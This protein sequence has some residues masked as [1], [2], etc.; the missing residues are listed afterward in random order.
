MFKLLIM[1]SGMK[2]LIISD[3][4]HP[5]VNGVVRSYEGLIPALHAQGHAVKVIGPD[6][7]PHRFGMVGYKEI[8]LVFKPYKRLSQMIEDYRP[9]TIHIATE[10]PLGWVARRYCLRRGIKFTSCY[11][12][13]F[14]EYFAK[15]FEKIWRGFYK[16]VYTIGVAVVKK[17]HAPSSALLVTTAS[18]AARLKKMGVQAPLHFF[19]RG[20]DNDF[21]HL[22]N[23]NLF[24]DLKKPVA[25]YVGRLAMEKNIGEFLEMDWAGSKV[26]VGHGPDE[27]TLKA[28]YPDAHFTGK[29]EGASLGDHYRSADVFVFPSCTDTFG[30]VLIE[31]LACGL[32]IAAHDVTGPCDVV[33]DENLGVL[34]P[35]LS[36][37]AQKALEQGGAAARSQHVR[38]H[39]SWDKAAEQFV[40][41]QKTTL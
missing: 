28:R 15:R 10:G 37:A 5:Q 40:E 41:A 23:K 25:L 30:M 32:P 11:H 4:W 38:Q 29:K 9:D 17:F 31:A 6:A 20:A 24:E 8:E 16:P 18:M 34:S 3:A 35:D 19:T 27:G 13:Q 26:V 39:Y 2:I 14:P 12:S 33:T 1:D 7:F 36:E 21:F 22:G